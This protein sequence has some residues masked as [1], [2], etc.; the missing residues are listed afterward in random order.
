MNPDF[1]L[2]IETAFA[3]FVLKTMLAFGLCLCLAWLAGSPS[4]R[5]IVWLSFL[6][7]T[8]AYWLW[9]AR[10]LLENR[11][12]P[13]ATPSTIGTVV[14]PVS[15]AAAA[16]QIPNAW[17]FPLG[18][19]LRLAGIVYVLILCSLLVI[20]LKKLR[21]LRWIL[22]FTSQPPGEITEAFQ[23]LAESLHVRRSRLL[24]LSGAS[25]PATFGWIRPI[26]VLPEICL[27]QGRP[28]LE[29]IL[30][31]E[32]HHVRRWDFCWN[33]LAIVCRALLCFHPAAWFAV[34]RMQF[35]RELA[36]DL[37]VVADSPKR[38]AN[39]AECLIRFARLN[40]SQDSRQWG[41]DFAAPA[42]HLKTRI[43]SILAVSK[44]PSPWLTG[45]RVACGLALLAGF[46]AVEPSLR[47]LI[48][49]AQEQIAQPLPEET[50][51]VSVKPRKRVR[52]IQKKKP[53]AA[54]A[55]A[56]TV[57]SLSP[58]TE[59]E[60]L[61]PERATGDSSQSPSATGPQLLHRGSPASNRNAKQQT[62][63]PIN[64]PSG[65]TSKSRD[66][67]RNQAVQQTASAAAGI[68]RRLSD[69]DRH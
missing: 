56:A 38:R 16:L 34:R 22:G 27:E 12:V 14:Q 5:F 67:D 55:P 54:S 50:Q 9:L 61:S 65:Q 6:Y 30:R 48:T 7:G 26:I 40:S 36:C 17:A 51:P 58:A 39:Y 15:S 53:L 62:V 64:D 32:L 25:S 8:A 13:T 33:W 59:P 42:E 4:R 63:V 46:L 35:E 11:Q 21:Q 2:G 20:E 69:L 60:D 66:H 31:H 45:S 10:D 1:L 24:M 49:Y 19:G 57:A 68:Y 47:V 37:A 28:E 52:A 41:V 18:I 43:R 44:K 3:G 29:D 23:P